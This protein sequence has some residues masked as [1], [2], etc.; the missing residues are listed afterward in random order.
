VASSPHSLDTPAQRRSGLGDRR[1][2]S[3]KQRDGS[4]SPSD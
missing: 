2:A 1:P 3:I 4:Q